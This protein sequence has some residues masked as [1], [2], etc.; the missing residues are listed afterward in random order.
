MKY[1]SVV[2]LILLSIFTS[3]SIYAQAA[4]LLDN[5]TVSES[6]GKVNIRLTLSAGSTCD[7][8]RF[9]RSPD[10]TNFEEIGHIAGVCGLSSFPTNYEF[11]DNDPIVNKKSYYKIELGV[12][13]Y[14]DVLSIEVMQLSSIDLIIRPNPVQSLT[15]VF[16]NNPYFET[17][18]LY[19]YSGTGQLIDI[20]ETQYDY[21]TLDFNDKNRGIYWVT[22]AKKGHLPSYRG[23][24]LVE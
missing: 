10:S 9:Y 1:P 11:L 12:Y 16:F 7:G 14:T 18:F 20:L 5:F 3:S 13:G 8:I 4:Y 19:L 21:F 22:I 2:L 15:T 17:H 6:N 23:K 24:V